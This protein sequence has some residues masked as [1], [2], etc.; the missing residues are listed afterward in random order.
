MPEDYETDAPIQVWPENQQAFGLFVD[1]QTQW[2]A[3]FGGLYGLDYCAAHG[4]L[5]LLELT[6]Q[7]KRDLM[8]D[9]RVMEAAALDQMAEDRG[10]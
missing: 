1:L 5:A 2:R 7:Q 8:D 10:Q 9:L 6:P 4:E 3:G